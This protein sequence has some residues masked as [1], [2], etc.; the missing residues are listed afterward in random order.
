MRKP[1]VTTSLAVMSVFLLAAAAVA[2]EVEKKPVEFRQLMNADGDALFGEFCATCHGLS[3]K[4]GGPAAVALAIKV[5]D[6]TALAAGNGG[7]YPAEEVEKSITGDAVVA[8]HG[9]QEMP[10]WGQAFSEAQPP[11]GQAPGK[12]FARLRIQN[13]VKYIETLQVEPGGDTG[14]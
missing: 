7:E 2:Q 6:L 1:T 9:S 12:E 4:G 13:L 3:G 8:A 10:I 11:W 14:K 5:P